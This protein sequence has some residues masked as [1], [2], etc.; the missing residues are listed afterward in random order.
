MARR[1]ALLKPV[2]LL[3]AVTAAVLIMRALDFETVLPRAR[4][5][6]DD[7][8]WAAPAVF[9]GLYAL[10]VIVAIPGWILTVTAAALFGVFGGTVVSSAGSVLGATG[11]FLIGRYLARD[12]VAR[13]VEG[14]ERF[15]KLD[16]TSERHGAWLVI[17][18]RFVPV[19]PFNVVNY[20]LGLTRV[21]LGTYVFWSWAA[22]LP[23]TIVYVV[24]AD[25]GFEAAAGGE[26]PWVWI[27]VAFVLLAAALVVGRWARRR[28][29]RL[30]SGS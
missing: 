4:A 15:R 22:M 6:I 8:G 18:V 25:A 14:R 30:E 24:G 17:L 10:A 28:F 27:V 23:W 13:W 26:W 12:A 5:W 9:V 29:E 20:A 2:L 21:R 7:L 11:A 1:P 19:M 16:A 3:V